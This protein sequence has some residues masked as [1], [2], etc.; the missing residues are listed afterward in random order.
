M[1][2]EN[3]CLTVI[4]G[5]H[6]WSKQLRAFGDQIET[7]PN[8]FRN[9]YQL[10][11]DRY[12]RPA[13]ISRGDAILYHSRT[14]H[15]S[16]PNNTDQPRIACLSACLPKEA[17]MIFHHR[18]SDTEVE[19]FAGDDDFYWKESFVFRRPENTPSLGMV[20]MGEEPLLSEEDLIALAEKTPAL[21]QR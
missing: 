1:T 15:G 20:D 9:V 3:G 5:S 14:I 7:S 11:R 2:E 16:L 18:H 10:L 13:P 19:A 17:Q 4:P 12:E 21:L 8:P 6:Q